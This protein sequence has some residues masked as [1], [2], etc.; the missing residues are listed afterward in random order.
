MP[1]IRKLG[2]LSGMMSECVNMGS[3]K[4][5]MAKKQEQSS[6]CYED[7]VWV[8]NPKIAFMTGRLT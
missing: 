7:N 8:T 2:I 4:R 6:P 5:G 3:L 1:D